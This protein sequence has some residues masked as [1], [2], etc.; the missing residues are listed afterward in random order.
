MGIDLC[1]PPSAFI[2]DFTL[3]STNFWFANMTQSL[4]TNATDWTVSPTGFNVSPGTPADFGANGVGPWGT[5]PGISAS[6]H[7]IWASG[8]VANYPDSLLRNSHLFEP[9][10]SRAAAACGPAA[11]VRPHRPGGL[12]EIFLS[13][14]FL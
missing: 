5:R 14:P 10:H 8:I 9:E 11:R 1:G 6:A 2:G 12:A 7:W 4:V 3:S 13:P